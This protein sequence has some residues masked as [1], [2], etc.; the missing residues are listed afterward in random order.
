MAT[1]RSR[2]TSR[3]GG[4]ADLVGDPGLDLADVGDAHRRR[5]FE[6]RTVGDEDGVAGILQN[7]LGDLD[8][9]IVEI[10]ERPVGFDRG[11][12]D[13]GVVDLELADEIT[14][15]RADDGAIGSRTVPP[16]TIT[17]MRGRW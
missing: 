12:A 4:I 10:E 16:A 17:S 6:L 13:D 2:Q 11:C 14:R 15:R 3:I 7:G 9:A 1:P 8:L 5:A